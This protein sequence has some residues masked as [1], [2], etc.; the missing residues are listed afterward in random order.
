[1]FRDPVLI[2]YLGSTRALVIIRAYDAGQD[3]RGRKQIV[4]LNF[5]IPPFEP[6]HPGDHRGIHE[7]LHRHG[8]NLGAADRCPD[9]HRGFFVL[10]IAPASEEQVSLAREIG[11]KLD[12][13]TPT[14]EFWPV[15]V[16]FVPSLGEA[17]WKGQT[18]E[19]FNFILKDIKEKYRVGFLYSNEN[20]PNTINF[21]IGRH[22]GFKKIG[23]RELY[24]R[25]L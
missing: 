8:I 16:A 7:I 5:E 3:E 23:N 18:I 22:G 6:H 9:K 11:E 1:M 25:M 15:P 2:P 24:A 13:G 21:L 14:A 4:Y 17:Q 20:H 19:T 12:M 10:F